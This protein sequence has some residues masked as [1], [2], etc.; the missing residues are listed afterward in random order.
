VS[1]RWMNSAEGIALP[2]NDRSEM[3]SVQV[4]SRDKG[5]VMQDVLPFDW[6]KCWWQFVQDQWQC[7]WMFSQTKHMAWGKGRI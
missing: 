4:N 5:G 3:R 1:P 6:I 7:L 2:C